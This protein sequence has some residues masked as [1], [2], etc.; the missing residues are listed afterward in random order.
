MLPPPPPP[1]ASDWPPAVTVVNEAG[2]SDWVVLCEH[3]SCHIPARYE[4]LGL[5]EGAE[6]AHIGWDLGAAD[7]ARALAGRLDA[8][9]AL[10]GYSRLLI[11]L[12]RPPGAPSSIPTLSEHVTIPGNLAL[13]EAERRSREQ[14][15]FHPFHQRV[16]DLLDARRARG[17]RTRLVTIHSFTPVFLGESRPWALGVLAGASRRL[18]EALLD[19]LRTAAAHLTM[20]L[21]QPY[22]IAADEDYAIPVH[23]DARGLDALLI[24]LR[25]DELADAADIAAWADRLARALSRI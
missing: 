1:D 25:N 12:N 2:G 5:S 4:R 24:E 18:A 7:L 10:G 6:R 23:G 15:L 19:E 8:A 9:L 13:T 20:A 17:R 22:R 21:D 14:R 16:A 3:A 11:D